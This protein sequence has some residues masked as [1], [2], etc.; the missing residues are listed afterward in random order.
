MK[1]EET[2]ETNYPSPDT[3]DRKALGTKTQPSIHLKTQ[4]NGL[5]TQHLM[6]P[7]EFS[8]GPLNYSPP[9]APFQA[10]D[11]S[12]AARQRRPLGPKELARPCPQPSTTLERCITTKFSCH[13]ANE[14]TKQ[15]HL[16]SKN[17]QT[18]QYIYQKSML[19]RFW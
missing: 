16:E 13:A 3:C 9:E 4:E 8:A 6:L 1:T 5:C 11:T 17:R 2:S 12:P 18:A 10:P 7:R 19:R 15:T 14:A